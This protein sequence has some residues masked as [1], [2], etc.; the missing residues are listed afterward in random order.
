MRFHAAIGSATLAAAAALTAAGPGTSADV[1]KGGAVAAP[2]P[3]DLAWVSPSAAGVLS[4]RVADLW[5]HP[6]LKANRV[7]LL[8]A[9]PDLV[10]GFEKQFGVKPAEVER[11]TLVLPRLPERGGPEPL[12]YLRTA[13]PYDRAK[14]VAAL[15]SA[16]REEKRKGLVL[17]AAGARA[18]ALL[19][20]RSFVQ[21][22]TGEVQSVADR[23]RAKG[24]GPLT[25][26]LAAAAAGHAVA[27]GGDPP[28]VPAANNGQLPRGAEPFRPLME[29]QHVVATADPDG[30]KGFR[31]EV[32]FHYPGRAKVKEG[33]EALRALVKL[34][35]G[36]LDA[37]AK[38][39]TASKENARVAD[40]LRAAEAGLRDAAVETRGTDVRLAV[41]VKA[42]PP[43]LI[44][45]LAESAARSRA[46]AGRAQSVNNLK[47]L[48]LAMHNYN[49]ATRRFPP[50]A[51]YDTDGKPLLSWRVLVLPYLDQN[52]LYKQ[53]R[54]DEP[55]DGP[56]NKK[57]LAKMPAVFAS[58]DARWKPGETGYRAFHG[59]G[60]FFEGKKGLPFASFT[61]GLSNTLMAV[62]AAESVPWTKPEEL[63]FDP[64]RD[65]V[66]FGFRKDGFLA[67]LCDGSVHFIRYKIKPETLKH[68]IMRND[69]FV[70]DDKE[71]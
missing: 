66:R 54:L 45:A 55:W 46:A 35:G 20:D 26:A 21:G 38:E 37:N 27:A 34:A 1:P 23:G 48:G 51:T 60:A 5:D 58:P 47:Q 63:P 41:A 24:E 40:L 30:G 13:K 50:A 36:A 64:D 31:G 16:A 57:L 4:V 65:V 2:L 32:R 3:P 17:Y 6:A 7:Q 28:A 11:L 62:E 19:D 44:A 15:G 71:F 18:V 12:V 67:L 52:E 70:I 22:E 61:D 49:D 8:E 68:L 14:V 25:P 53:F 69:G 33:A 10:P 43:A 56:N 9:V 39:L 42:D 29:A 59:K